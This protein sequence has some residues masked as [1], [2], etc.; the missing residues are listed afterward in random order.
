MDIVIT[1]CFAMGEEMPRIASSLERGILETR[2]IPFRPI[3]KEGF[4]FVSFHT[5]VHVFFG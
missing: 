1:I 4:A 5:L 2:G 3:L